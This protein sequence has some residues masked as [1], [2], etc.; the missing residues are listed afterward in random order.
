MK[1]GK[2]PHCYVVAGPNG[3]GKTTFALKY[4][5]RI[6]SCRD[7]INADEIAK[8]LSPL[9][10][11]AGLLRAS[12]IFLE[13]LNRKIEDRND[14]AFETT[15]SGRTYLPRI[16]EWRKSGWIVTLFYL[17]I[18]DAEFS[19]QRVRHR[20]LEGGH[21]IPAEDIVRRYP[22]SIRNLFDYAEVCD[23]TRCVDNSEEQ[24]VPIFEK[25]FGRPVIVQDADRFSKMQG[26]LG[27]GH[28]ER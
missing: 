26:V 24:I 19:A 3:A 22:R 16:V 9:D 17:Y 6:V 1:H 27:H 2:Q 23:H 18:P 15:L 21:D 28:N 25:E 8:G 4:L 11:E 13:T 12:K 7:F 10:Y 20:V 14:F 5:P